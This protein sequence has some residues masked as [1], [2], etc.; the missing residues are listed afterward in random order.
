MTI[1]FQLLPA[2]TAGPDQN[3]CNQGTAKMDGNITIPGGGVWSTSGTGTFTPSASQLNATYVPSAADVTKGSVELTLTANNPGQCYIPSDK[4]TV[5]LIPPP[6]VNAGGTL[7]VL[8]G[9][10]KTLEPTVS[11]PNVTYLWSP[12]ADISST[13]IKNPVITGNV[14]RT[15][16]LTVT[17]S[18]GCVSSDQVK[19]IVSPQIIVPNAF[20]PNGDGYND[21]W[22][23]T[24]MTAYVHGTVDVFDRYG[25]RV[26]HSVGYGTPWDGT[27][28][29]KQVPYGVYYYIIDPKFEK[30]PLVSGYV[31]VIR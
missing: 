26:F 13:T 16:T 8:K 3:I 6:T 29:G 24:G 14:D 25:Q 31:T 1:K 27:S 28:N 4:M 23:I 2:V 12:D 21:Q 20:T 7:Y 5:R 17:D 9:Y 11:D 19:V 18:R 15:Y 10:T 22:N 30:M